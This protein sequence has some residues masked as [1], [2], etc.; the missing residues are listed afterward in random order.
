[1]GV[2]VRVRRRVKNIVRVNEIQRER[3]RESGKDRKEIDI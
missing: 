3:E 1:V 2:Y